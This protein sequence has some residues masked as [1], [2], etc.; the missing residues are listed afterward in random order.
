MRR[1]QGSLELPP[2]TKKNNYNDIQEL[3]ELQEL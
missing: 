1:N 3:Q 2:L